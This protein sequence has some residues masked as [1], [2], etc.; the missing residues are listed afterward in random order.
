MLDSARGGAGGTLIVR[1]DPGAGKSVLLQAAVAQ[2][3]EFIIM[4]STA[5][6]SESDL[7]FG[8]LLGL[9]GPYLG[10]LDALPEG[11]R[12]SLRCALGLDPTLTEPVEQLACYG[13]VVS[14]LAD[15]ARDRPLLVVADDL[16]WFDAGSRDAILFAARRMGSDAA[17][18]L[19][20]VRD[21]EDEMVG[22][23]QLPELALGGLDADSATRL[24]RDDW[25]DIAPDVAHEIWSQTAGNALAL[26]EIPRY[27][28]EQQL[29][30]GE[31]LDEPLPVGRR[32]EEGF[33]H[34]VVA[35]PDETQRA[36][37]VAA[38]SFGMDARTIGAALGQLELSIDALEPAEDAG[39]LLISQGA[40][41]WR[42]PLVRSAVYQRTS[43]ANRR[44]AHRAL[45]ATAGDQSLADHRAWHLAAAA[46]SADEGVAADLERVAAEAARRGAL[47]VAMRALQHATR[48]SPDDGDRSRRATGAAEHAVNVGKWDEALLLIDDARRHTSDPLLSAHAERVVARVETLRGTPVAAS[49]RLV[50]LAESVR[51]ADV[52]L[53][54]TVMTEAVVAHMATGD[55]EQF[56]GTA[57]RAFELSRSV[58]GPVEAI[59]GLV[60]GLGLIGF[61]HLDHALEL[62]DR[63]APVTDSPEL[64]RAAPEI[65]GTFAYANMVRGDYGGSERLL[66]RMIDAARR[67]GAVRAL[68]YPLAQ[69]S[70]V[71]LALGRW[72]AALAD[73]SEAVELS[74]GMFNGA[75]RAFTW[76]RLSQAE[77]VLGHAQAA[78]AAAENCIAMSRASGTDAIEPYGRVALA[79]LALSEADG[80]E[81]IEQINSAGRVCQEFAEPG[82][83]QTEGIV[84]E[85]YARTGQHD[86]A[87]RNV[88]EL[89]LAAADSISPW[90]AMTVARCRGIL[91]PS[92]ECDQYFEEAL[93]LHD[94][95]PLPFERARTELCYGE[96]LRRARRRT[97]ARGHLMRATTAFAEL[98]ATLWSARAERELMLAGQRRRPE[99]PLSPWANL[100]AAETRV[101]EVIIEGATYAEAAT[102]LFVESQNGRDPPSPDLPQTRGS[103]SQRAN[104]TPGVG[105][106]ARSDRQ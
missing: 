31:P 22:D 103:L 90:T 73:A 17:V 12:Q 86:R 68:C 1:G 43:A 11:Q 87:V 61:G 58:G 28:T 25:R 78:R 79:T 82:W 99:R 80:G 52:A 5:V 53:S 13:A 3:R 35:L 14:V 106:N 36:L 24:L 96:R 10:R 46:T 50:K 85:A 37:V 83:F 71:L 70:A 34:R 84:I 26:T 77:A 27:L 76:G 104:S 7:A 9:L 56:M 67:D 19:M 41:A 72:P 55:R 8:S 21:G 57:E 49:A 88:E 64:W 59:A 60:V 94:H 92:P 40:V 62:L 4:S 74:E 51:A 23:T 98:G 97:D 30:G 42:H 33:A 18:F 66:S 93:A 44:G 69:R 6:E 95:L 38:A 48:L 102:A 47:E 101:A 15:C 32:L 16:Q 105:R 65:V 63:Y 39:L 2:A 91:A 81:A 54:A 29:V 100:T 45:A 75:M 89:H 20:S